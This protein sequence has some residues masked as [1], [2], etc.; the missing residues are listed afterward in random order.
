MTPAAPNRRWFRWSLRTLFVAVT[1]LCVWLGWQV[2]VVQQRRAMANR[3]RAEGGSV[4]LVV[5]S[6]E[7]ANGLE[8]SKLDGVAPNPGDQLLS[9]V[10]YFLRVRQWWLGDFPATYVELPVG[11]TDLQVQ[12]ATSVFPEAEVR[13]RP[14]G[15]PRLPPARS[16]H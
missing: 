7:T 16:T 9:S 11:S 1:V 6:G 2:N 15:R 12:R 10:G 13:I 5:V 3:I 8:I 14:A 4:V